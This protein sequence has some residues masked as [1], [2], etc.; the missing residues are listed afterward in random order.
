MDTFR[1]YAKAPKTYK[2]KRFGKPILKWDNNI[3]INIAGGNVDSI[4]LAAD[5]VEWLL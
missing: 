3:E 5:W 2:K 1:D 4:Y